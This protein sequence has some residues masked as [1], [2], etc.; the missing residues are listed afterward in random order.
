[1]TK[2]C[3]ISRSFSPEDKFNLEEREG[4]GVKDGNERFASLTAASARSSR[5][6]LPS[7]GKEL[8]VLTAWVTIGGV[9]PMEYH[10]GRYEAQGR[11]WP[12]LPPIQRDFIVS[13]LILIGKIKSIE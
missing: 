5:L 12:A 10:K 6:T 4:A 8:L 9:P 11:P 1:M 7:G 13:P 3:E 2:G